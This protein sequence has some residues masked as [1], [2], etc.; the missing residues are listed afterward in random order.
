[1]EMKP[2]VSGADERKMNREWIFCE[3]LHW[4]V[5]GSFVKLCFVA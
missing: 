2:E 1:M 4:H 5:L 3:H